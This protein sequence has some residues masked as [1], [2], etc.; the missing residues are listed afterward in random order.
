MHIDFDN[1]MNTEQHLEFLNK[2]LELVPQVNSPEFL[3]MVKAERFDLDEIFLIRVDAFEE[4]MDTIKALVYLYEV[5]E[6]EESRELII[7]LY[8]IQQYIVYRE[9]HIDTDISNKFSDV[10]DWIDYKEWF[11]E[12]VVESYIKDVIRGNIAFRSQK[13]SPKSYPGCPVDEIKQA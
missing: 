11:N 3:N 5:P 12:S 10:L 1:A 9:L 2:V 8:D 13:F 4:G 6:I 7:N